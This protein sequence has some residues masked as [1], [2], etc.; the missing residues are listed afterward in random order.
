MGAYDRL[1]T[2]KFTGDVFDRTVFISEIHQHPGTEPTQ[3]HIYV[4]VE[5]NIRTIDF[6][7]IRNDIKK[8]QH[9]CREKLT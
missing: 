5:F 2:T 8:S 3:A 9:D 1:Q 6:E 4:L 7:N